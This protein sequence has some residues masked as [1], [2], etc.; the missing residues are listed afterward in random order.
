ML[1]MLG[2]FHQMKI[3]KFGY[4]LEKGFWFEAV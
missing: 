4:L 1:V 2:R 3:K